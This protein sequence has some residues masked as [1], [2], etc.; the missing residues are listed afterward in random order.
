MDYQNPASAAGQ[1]AA[2]TN[3]YPQ[4]KG[5]EVEADR[6][7]SASMTELASTCGDVETEVRRLARRI[8]GAI[9]G[10]SPFDMLDKQQSVTTGIPSGQVPTPCRS[11]LTEEIQTRIYQLRELAKTLNGIVER[12]EL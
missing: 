1:L 9:P 8:A 6:A 4:M 11:H 12:I 2:A 5:P 7:I 3:R 10:G